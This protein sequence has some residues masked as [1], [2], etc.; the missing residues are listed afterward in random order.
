MKDYSPTDSEDLLACFQRVIHNKTVKQ[1]WHDSDDPISGIWYEHG[2]DAVQ[3]KYD[4]PAEQVRHFD[5]CPMRFP[6]L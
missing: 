1:V 4:V 6:D 2:Y 3:T 5:R